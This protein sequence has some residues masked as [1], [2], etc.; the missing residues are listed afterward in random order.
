[1]FFKKFFVGVL[2]VFGLSVWGNAA[3]SKGIYNLHIDDS[4]YVNTNPNKFRSDDNKV[5]YFLSKISIF[6][7][8]D[9]LYEADIAF[10]N[11]NGF[12]P[13]IHKLFNKTGSFGLI[14]LATRGLTTEKTILVNG[15]SKRLKIIG[16]HNSVR[17]SDWASN[18]TI[19]LENFYDNNGLDNLLV[20]QGFHNQFKLYR[21]D[22]DESIDT[23]HTIYIITGHSQGGSIAKLYGASLRQRGVP[24]E[25][26]LVY[27]FGA[28]PVTRNTSNF[29]NHFNVV[30]GVT[31]LYIFETANKLDPAYHLAYRKH[32]STYFTRVSDYAHFSFN[33]SG[34]VGSLGFGC[35]VRGIFFMENWF[36]N[37]F[38]NDDVERPACTFSAHAKALYSYN[39][40]TNLDMTSIL[41]QNIL[42]SNPDEDVSISFNEFQL[43]EI[44]NILKQ[45]PNYKGVVGKKFDSS[46]L[47][48]LERRKL[49]DRLRE[50]QI[51]VNYDQF[52]ALGQAFRVT[53][54]ELVASR[55]PL[56]ASAKTNVNIANLQI[57]TNAE[58]MYG[59][60]LNTAAEAADI[61]TLGGAAAVKL[62]VKGKTFGKS[63]WNL[64]NLLIRNTYK[65]KGKY[66]RKV[67]A[68]FDS[69]EFKIINALFMSGFELASQEFLE[70]SQDE[71][72][73]AYVKNL[74]DIQG[75][76]INVAITQTMKNKVY[77]KL[78]EM[79]T[80]AGASMLRGASEVTLLDEATKEVALSVL[81]DVT[82]IIPFAGPLYSQYLLIQEIEEKQLN[83]P[84]LLEAWYEYDTLNNQ[85]IEEIKTLGDATF[86]K[87]LDIVLN[88]ALEEL[89]KEYVKPKELTQDIPTLL[90][91]L[92]ENA[93]AI[94]PDITAPQGETVSFTPDYAAK[95][96]IECVNDATITDID[97]GVYYET[98][99]ADL[100]WK[101]WYVDD[102]TGFGGTD[103]TLQREGNGFS[104]TSPKSTSIVITSIT[105]STEGK[106]D[107]RSC[108]LPEKWQI[109]EAGTGDT[110]TTATNPLKQTGQTTS[111]T[112]GDDGSYRAGATPSYT[113]SAAGVV[114]DHITGLE[115]Q[116]DYSD[117]GGSV[118]QTTWQGALDYCSGLS[119]DGG[120]WRLPSI[121]AL[122]TIV[123]SSRYN[124]SIDTTVFARISSDGYWSSTTHASGTS[125]AWFVS[126]SYGY[127]NDYGKT[128]SGYVR[129]V[130]GGQ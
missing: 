116:D 69:H 24:K 65:L 10:L 120:G 107:Q 114:T 56:L 113:R 89:K 50:L 99:N 44:S 117:N 130:R 49:I 4:S 60:V 2:L 51:F 71:K 124:P 97:G 70:A 18:A 32:F 123:D 96:F 62:V 75:E 34:D 63:L 48:K 81:S 46:K 95:S 76:I 7:T 112:A 104:F 12:V 101:L 83:D 39:F 86:V 53:T 37:W 3:T 27:T 126:F 57:G 11:D 110:N 129:C 105:Y 122:E 28:L 66:L 92:P 20:H 42:D 45:Y 128:G 54:Q 82:E 33:D 78:L 127:S 77:A 58:L 109:M 100:E 22:E 84:A 74:W 8:Q 43:L 36:N 85:L 125:G 6:A 106:R 26:V 98:A 93:T 40:Y 55:Q 52:G 16:F 111:Y 38:G 64:N 94:Y 25:N 17:A 67:I 14:N 108:S 5:A 88:K 68:V 13:S 41:E 73:V 61:F 118:K 80:E 19:S 9:E 115:W 47:T 79:L 87:R 72:S 121:K 23:Q 30:N 21:E 90:F 29:A 59:T 119:L 103:I 102:S 15:I 91:T 1:M 31:P 35:D